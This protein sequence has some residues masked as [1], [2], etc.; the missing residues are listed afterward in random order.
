[1]EKE[2]WTKEKGG[3]RVEKRWKDKEAEQ[4][5]TSISQETIIDTMLITMERMMERLSAD[6][7]PPP[8]ENHEQQNRNQNSWRPQVIHNRQRNPLD[9]PIM[10][11]F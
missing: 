9:S 1:M 4:P 6:G 11:P 5:S 8:G 3:W 10:P 7:R 2:G